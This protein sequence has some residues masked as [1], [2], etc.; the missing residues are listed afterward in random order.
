MTDSQPHRTVDTFRVPDG[1]TG[2]AVVGSRHDGC[3]FATFE[4]V[5]GA[6]P[7]PRRELAGLFERLAEELEGQA[8]ALDRGGVP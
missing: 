6:L 3:H 8:D 5:P 2:I 4:E 1:A 7:V